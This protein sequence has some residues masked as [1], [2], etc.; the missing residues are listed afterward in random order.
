[1]SQTQGF[2]LVPFKNFKIRTV[3]PL[4]PITN[5][6]PIF[7]LHYLVKFYPLFLYIF[8]VGSND[9]YHDHVWMSH[10]QTVYTI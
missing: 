7:P 3:P 5:D 9:S 1:M 4:A 10:T 6:Y 2:Y 8:K